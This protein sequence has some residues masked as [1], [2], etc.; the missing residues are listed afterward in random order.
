MNSLFLMLLS[1]FGQVSSWKYSPQTGLCH[2]PPYL[3][4]RYR[5]LLCLYF[6]SNFTVSIEGEFI[7]HFPYYL[8][9]GYIPFF[10]RIDR[11]II[12]SA[13]ADSQRF[14]LPINAHL[15][16]NTFYHTGSLPY[17]CLYFFFKYSFSIFIIPRVFRASSYF[18]SDS[19]SRSA[20]LFGPSK[21]SG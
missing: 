15:G 1:C 18:S 7:Q 3:F 2:N 14:T 8:E 4:L 21:I 11:A 12:G 16:V 10:Q 6:T 17:S 9:N 13:P 19:F 5:D 20:L